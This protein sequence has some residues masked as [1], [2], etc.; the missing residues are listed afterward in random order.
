M[1]KNRNKFS[2]GY[3]EEPTPPTPE[4]SWPGYMHEPGDRI[5]TE[6]YSP[7]ASESGPP[8]V[9]DPV[10]SLEPTDAID[11]E[12]VNHFLRY[13]LNHP[14]RNHRWMRSPKSSSA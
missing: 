5:P 14:P 3:S 11:H 8:V 4:P 2:G 12:V 1:K 13:T 10:A 6:S 9:N 7:T